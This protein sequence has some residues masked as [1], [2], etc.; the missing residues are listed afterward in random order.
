VDAEATAAALSELALPGIAFRAC[1]FRPEF[2]KHRRSVCG[3]V[4]LHVADRDRLEPV[5]LGL[6]LIRTIRDLHPEDFEWRSEPYE[7][8]S[9]VPAIDLLTGSSET[10]QHIEEGTDLEPLLDRWKRWVGDFES[11]LDEIM[12][13]H[14]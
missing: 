1:R 10:R 12:L 9:D 8:V 2:G 14:D 3:G 6:H 4:E 11:G 7:F 5:A 13:Y